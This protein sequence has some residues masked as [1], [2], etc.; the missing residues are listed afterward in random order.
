MLEE[1]NL[2]LLLTVFFICQVRVPLE[3]TIYNNVKKIFR[4][5]SGDFERVSPWDLEKIPDGLG[6]FTYLRII[7]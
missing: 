6:N 5:D 3:C 7:M 1:N 2:F 4:W